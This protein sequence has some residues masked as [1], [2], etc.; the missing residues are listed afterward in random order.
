MYSGSNII[1]VVSLL[2]VLSSAVGIIVLAVNYAQFGDFIAMRA[3]MHV[4][5]ESRFAVQA[6]G[7]QEA[8]SNPLGNG[9]SQFSLELGSTA[10]IGSGAAHSLF[11]RLLFENEIGGFLSLM[12]FLGL[13]FNT[14][15]GNRMAFQRDGGCY[16]SSLIGGMVNSAV[17]DTF[18]WR[19]F[20]IQLGIIWG[21]YAV[22]K[23]ESTVG[24]VLR[25]R[26]AG[27]LFVHK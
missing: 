24:S 11:V 13:S 4:Y 17:I 20:W 16:G 8:L 10:W 23:R 14:L 21:L 2:I 12:M 1:K 25:A 9:P 18:H 7:L 27:D 5:G 19:H 6:L 22:Y 15:G 26:V 3:Q